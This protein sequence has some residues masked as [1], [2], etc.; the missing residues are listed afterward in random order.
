MARGHQ[1][2][3]MDSSQ[4]SFRIHSIARSQMSGFDALANSVL[5]LLVGRN[6]ISS[7]LHDFPAACVIERFLAAIECNAD[8]SA[9]ALH[10]VDISE[11]ELYSYARH[12]LN[13]A[14]R[15]LLCLGFFVAGRPWRGSFRGRFRIPQAKS[16]GRRLKTSDGT[17]LHRLDCH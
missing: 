14:I 9:R 12:T 17:H 4:V 16:P 10:F 1:A 11:I 15:P 5:D 7:L 13:R 6:A 8:S 3:Q 2:D